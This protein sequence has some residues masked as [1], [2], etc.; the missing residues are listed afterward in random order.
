GKAWMSLCEGHYNEKL[1]PILINASPLAG[2]DDA[3][4]KAAMEVV[5]RDKSQALDNLDKVRLTIRERLGDV[6]LLNH[7]IGTKIRKKKKAKLSH[8]QANR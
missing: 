3:P 8:P 7:H 5:M 1:L 4:Y 6:T 2:L